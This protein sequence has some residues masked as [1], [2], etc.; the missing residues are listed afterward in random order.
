LQWSYQG[1]QFT[2]P[3]YAGQDLPFYNRFQAHG[4]LDANLTYTAPKH[5]TVGAY[6]LNA[7]NKVY[8]ANT[9]DIG[10]GANGLLYNAP[11]QFGIRATYA[12]GANDK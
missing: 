6:M 4:I 10:L 1:A 7:T 9:I 11:R 3:S 8:V 12:F 5:W 2:I